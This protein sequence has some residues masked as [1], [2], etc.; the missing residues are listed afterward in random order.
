M[1][2]AGCCPKTFLPALSLSRSWEG[3]LWFT[4]R[5]QP[6]PS[7]VAW[8]QAG[9]GRTLPRTHPCNWLREPQWGWGGFWWLGD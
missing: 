9:W 7:P 8:S 4:V 2:W 6:V 1:R 5:L 3:P